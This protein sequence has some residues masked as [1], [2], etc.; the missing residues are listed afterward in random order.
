MPQ[1]CTLFWH[2]QQVVYR[3]IEYRRVEVQ[4]DVN[5]LEIFQSDL[6]NIR[7]CICSIR[8]TVR[9]HA[10]R[11]QLQLRIQL[12]VCQRS[13]YSRL[14][15]VKCRILVGRK[16]HEKIVIIVELVHIVERTLVSRVRA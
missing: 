14:V 13:D 12:F 8:K 10:L 2:Q 6:E 16:I 15:E 9:A 11:V 4:A 7:I 1:T 5:V 3:L